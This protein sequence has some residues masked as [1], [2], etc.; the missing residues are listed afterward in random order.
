MKYKVLPICIVFSFILLAPFGRIALAD[1]KPVSTPPNI[2]LIFCDDL[3]YA[4]ITPFGSKK[5]RTPNL[6]DL[7]QQGRKFT[8]FYVTSGV[9]TPSRA[10]LMTG[11]YPKRISLHQN[12]SNG[13][14]LFPG[15]KTGLNPSEITIAEVLKRKGYATACIGKWH[16]GDQPPFLPTRQGFDYYFGIPFSNDMGYWIPRRNYPPLPLMRNEKVIEEE[17]DQDYLTQRY[18]TE[19]LQFIEANKSK[20]FFLY[21]P[22]SMPHAPQAASPK[23]KGKSTNGLWGDSVE[24]IDWST[25]QIM[26]KLKQLNIHKN[27]IT[28][29]LSDNGGATR[30]GASN[31][32]LRGA[33]GSTWE[34]GHRV[35]FLI[36]W[37]DKI[38][39]GT[40]TDQLAT[41]MDL[42]PT[43]ATFARA[44]PPKDRII[45]GK[46]IS[47]LILGKPDAQTPHAA[48][49]YYF[50][51]TLHAVRSGKWKLMVAW[52]GKVK[53]STVMFKSPVLLYNLDKDISE[54]TNVAK[55]NPGV[56]KRLLALL[57]RA[58]HDLG[59]DSRRTKTVGENTRKP[60]FYQNA[61]TLTRKKPKTKPSNGDAS[62]PNIIIVFTDDQGY[63]DLSCFGAKDFKTPHIDSL[64]KEGM[65][66][67]SFYVAQAVCGA[68]RAALLTGC[69]PN[70]IGLLGAPGP[71]AKH[72][73][74]KNE[75]T[76]AE[77]L[78]QKNY[79]TAIYGKWHLGHRKPFLPTQHGFDEY[80]GLPYSNDMWPFHPWQGKRFRFPDLP[81]YKNNKV[82]N[83]K[84]T[85]KD[86]TQLTTQYTRHAVEFINRNHKKPFFLYVAHSMPHVPLYVSSKYKGKT[87][88]GIYGD[89]IAEIDWSVGQILATLKKHNIDKNTLII[90]TSDNGPWLSYGTHGGSARPLREGKGTTWE[91]GVRVPCVMRWPARIPAGKTCDKIA[92]TIDILPTIAKITKTQL[93]QHTIDGEDILPLLTAQPNAN[94]RD[95]YLYY[96]GRHLQAVRAHHYKLHFPH[97]YR[98]MNGKPGG[99]D[100]TP[101][102]YTTLRTPLALYDLKKDPSERH[103]I[104]DKHP[105][106]VKA[107][108][109]LA[110]AARKELGD[111]ATRQKGTNIRP[112]GRL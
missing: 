10:S 70:R 5:H 46:N 34:G 43:L 77:L 52:R 108:Q 7:A 103:N 37:P 41:S 82:V 95:T 50:R 96:W 15:N 76:I 88:N 30:W 2:I 42:L 36:S 9:C 80:F 92:A 28:I 4:D 59:D 98:S 85:P 48:Y 99:T 20:P 29:F 104:I 71:N 1:K 38:P 17:P 16:L 102:P 45:D 112:A 11:C 31:A 14:V 68:S 19:A 66:F 75:L 65:K 26:K 72:G 107:L 89:V 58:R 49:F 55:Q 6:D 93:P 109:R 74:H 3:G 57:Q 39:R 86:Q 94:P 100:G 69:Y 79:A 101:N 51:G 56:V 25:G 110:N 78:K 8:S 111:S 18:T 27:T 97:P 63:A 64:A 13:W 32:P 90:Y 33:K 87:E 47:D 67:T 61:K 53:D 91:G 23:F 21:L 62:M 60:G 44:S 22:H 35:P 12:E 106:V 73:I 105:D 83:P 84:V 54:T 24:E 81:L 40:S